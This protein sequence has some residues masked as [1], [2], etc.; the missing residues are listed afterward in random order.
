MKTHLRKR[1]PTKRCYVCKG[2]DHHL[3]KKYMNRGKIEDEK[4]SKAY[5]IKTQMK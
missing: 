2:L 5:N 4:K 1:N 3:A